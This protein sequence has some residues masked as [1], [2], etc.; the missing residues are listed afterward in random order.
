MKIRD[1]VNR[2]EAKLPREWAEEWD[3]VG[4]LVGDA[5][6]D[7]SRI[8]VALDATVSSINAAAD[9]GCTMLVAHHPIIF[10]PTRR[11]L[12][13][14]VTHRPLFA[15]IE[16]GMAVYAAH[17]NWDASPDG[18]NAILAGMLSMRSLA[19]MTK[20]H[21]DEWGLGV[22]GDLREPMNLFELA[23]HARHVWRLSQI[24]IFAPD[25]RRRVSRAAILGGAGGDFIADA[26][27]SGAEVYITADA[28]YH[29]RLEA[30]TAGLPLV[31]PDH[32]EMEAATMPHLADLVR[33]ATGVE[34]VLLPHSPAAPTPV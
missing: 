25:S 28:N 21:G 6:A 19:P 29:V 30:E 1:I 22:V 18:V 31:I 12:H 7:V 4:L 27:R 10:K 20:P 32:G 11:L 24:S 17:T 26:I 13:D 34:T 15:A 8:A 9:A 3:N 2:I 14:D 5:Q 23:T 16:R 33:G